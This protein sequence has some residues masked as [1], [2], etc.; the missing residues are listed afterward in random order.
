[1]LWLPLC[2][3]AF[4][5]STSL[6]WYHATENYIRFTKHLCILMPKTKHLHDKDED[7]LT[8]FSPCC[9]KWPEEE[10]GVNTQKGPLT[11]YKPLIALSQASPCQTFCFQHDFDVARWDYLGWMCSALSLIFDEGNYLKFKFEEDYCNTRKIDHT[12]GLMS[13]ISQVQYSVVSLWRSQKLFI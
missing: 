10:A 2:W 6:V 8:C 1:M 5:Y 9:C 12:D 7:G 4:Y 13:I 3:I 11:F